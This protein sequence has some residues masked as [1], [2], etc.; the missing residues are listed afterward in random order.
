MKHKKGN[1]NVGQYDS[2]NK[3]SS[4]VVSELPPPPAYSELSSVILTGRSDRTEHDLLTS[5]SDRTDT[6]L[7]ISG[8]SSKHGSNN[9]GV[10]QGIKMTSLP[11]VHLGSYQVTVFTK[12]LTFFIYEFL[13]RGNLCTFSLAAYSPVLIHLPECHLTILHFFAD[14]YLHHPLIWNML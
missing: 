14:S 10:H 12:N 6:G 5:C 7:L 3:Q 4:I 9:D 1:Y 13:H 8:G 11:L 2:P